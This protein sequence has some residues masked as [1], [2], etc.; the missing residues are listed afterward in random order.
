MRG[1]L[2]PRPVSLEGR[3][4]DLEPIYKELVPRV[5]GRVALASGDE[6]FILPDYSA[7]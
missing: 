2:N 1:C 3:V 7:D 6:V 4:N 5:I